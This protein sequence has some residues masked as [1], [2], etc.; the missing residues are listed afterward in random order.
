MNFGPVDNLMHAGLAGNVFPGA[1][2]LVAREGEVLFHRAYGWADLF[3][4]RLMTVETCF[5]LASLTKPLAAAMAVMHLVQQGVLEVEQTCGELCPDLRGSDKAAISVR[6]LLSHCSG[7]P[8]WRP[9]FMR[10]RGLEPESRIAVLRRA[11]L[12]EPLVCAAGAGAQYSDLGFLMLQWVI[13]DLVR[14]PLDAYVSEKLY[15]PLGIDRLYF[16]SARRRVEMSGEPMAAT[17][18]CPWRNR[19]LVGEVHDDNAA[20]L[21]GNAA[22]AGLFGT[23]LSV[24]GLLQGL[25]SAEQGGHAHPLFDGAL[26]RS[27]FQ[28][29]PGDTTWALGFDTP[30]PVGSSAGQWFGAESVG[31]LGFTG[32]SFWMDRRRAL[33]VVLLTN[34][35]HPSRYNTGIRAFRPQLHDAVAAAVRP[36]AQGVKKIN[37]VPHRV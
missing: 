34:R 12:A 9:Y 10:L 30:S 22:H 23:A 17:E 24:Q 6:Q 18:L 21:N 20:V 16:A 33:I 25:L 36:A 31:H 3:S 29:Q 11:L 2:L 32:T 35:V 8:P 15:R 13:E 37:C 1:V 5:D 27:F 28:R 7:L 14:Q 4:R 19:L 26:I